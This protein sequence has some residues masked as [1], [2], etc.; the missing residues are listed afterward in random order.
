M[1][2]KKIKTKEID[3]IVGDYEKFFKKMSIKY[4]DSH[5]FMEFVGIII[6]GEFFKTSLTKKEFKK[7]LKK[8][9]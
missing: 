6:L 9:E 5:G 7:L 3:K 4:A 8:L 2:K 1:R